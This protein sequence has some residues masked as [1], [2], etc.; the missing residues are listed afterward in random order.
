MPAVTVEN[1]EFH[2][3]KTGMSSEGAKVLHDYADALRALKDAGVSR[4]PISKDL[5]ANLAAIGNAMKSIDSAGVSMLRQ[6]S[7]ALKTFSDLKSIKL[8]A[9]FSQTLIQIADATKKIDDDCINRLNKLFQALQLLKGAKT[10]IGDKLPI[11]IL[12]LNSAMQSITDETIAKIHRLT[13]A[14]SRLKGVD[15]SGLGAV[16]KGQNDAW[17]IQRQQKKQWNNTTRTTGGQTGTGSIGQKGAVNWKEAIDGAKKFSNTVKSVVNAVVKELKKILKVIGA[18]GKGFLSI[19]GKSF[20]ITSIAR[21][22]GRIQK[23]IR[24]FGRVAFYRAVRTAIKAVNEAFKE[25]AENAYWYSREFGNATKYISEAFDA[26]KSSSFKTQNQ[27]GAAWA[28]L[29]SAIEPVLIQILN[30]ISRAAEAVTEFFA[31]LG[32]QGTYLRAIDY[33]K[34]WAES[35]DKAG[36]AAKEWR[37]QLMGF[38]EINRLDAPSDGNGGGGSDMPEYGK[39][40]EEVPVANNY[41]NNLIDAFKNGAWAK[42]GELI[43]EKINNLVDRVNWEDIGRKIGEKINALIQ[44]AYAALKKIDFVNIGRSLAEL[45]IGALDAIDFETAGRLLIRKFTALFDAV[46]GFIMTPGLWSKLAKAIGD[47]FH[48]ALSEASEWLSRQ[49]F[50]EVAATLGNGILNVLMRVR[51]EIKEHREVFY[52]IGQAI[53]QMLTNIPWI[54]IL[55][56]LAEALWIAFKGVIDGLFSTSGGRVFLA[57]V[58]G[59]KLLQGAFTLAIPLLKVAAEAFVKEAL[60]PLLGLGGKITQAGTEAATAAAAIGPR[61]GAGIATWTTAITTAISEFTIAGTTLLTGAAGALA[62]AALAVTDAVI[63]SY[64][65]KSLKSAQQTYKAAL[66][67]HTKETKTA[68]DSYKKLYE[69]KGKE[70]ADEWAKMVYNI[71]TSAMSLSEA[72]HAIARE[73]EHNWDD[74]PQNMWQG[75][76]QG[77]DY[78]FG[79]G[80]HGGIIVLFEDAF[81]GAVNAVKSFLGINSPSTVFAEIGRNLVEGLKNGFTDA[82]GSFI[83][84]A[85]SLVSSLVSELTNSMQSAI[86]TASNKLN[87]FVNSAKSTIGNIASSIDS[88]VGKAS[89]K[90][91]SIVGS[92]KN[93]MNSAVT[94]VTTAASNIRSAQKSTYTYTPAVPVFASG[95]FPEDGLFYANHG[96][97]I[98]QFANGHTAVANNDQIVEGISE[99]VYQAVT[100]ALS[101]G[102]VANGQPVNIYMDGKLIAQSTTRYQKQFA[103]ATG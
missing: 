47:F 19:V 44:F 70:V 85:K 103:R 87:S 100:A 11:Q 101:S 64:D 14:L 38:D 1:L 53:G 31:I 26:L 16:L 83:S 95:G 4:N 2:I 58:A 5:A 96:E 39:M 20:G 35:A 28:T 15:L 66:D 43:G 79:N 12:N 27:L 49:N 89:S 6:L 99:G 93:A 65:V 74:V 32:G 75:F 80:S 71:D 86:Q 92:V 72:Q 60:V 17:K 69:E 48:G 22:V 88:V 91:S 29:L 73:V 62:T 57:M 97:M 55:K 81:K 59:L 84:A 102:N 23:V 82:F 56:T 94:F 42:L 76:K 77:W 33:N 67:A 52:Q 25:G 36:K 41:L 50:A 61:I 40:F 3:K 9:N 8:D 78:Y 46:I 10:N 7:N 13:W 37:N 21:E 30:L 18:I 34:Q 54:D 51:D 68:L 45:L 98:G 90:L 63:L 24:S